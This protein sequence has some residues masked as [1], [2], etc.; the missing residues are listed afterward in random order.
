MEKIT[1]IYGASD[2][3]EFDGAVDGEVGCLRSYRSGE[4]PMSI[5]TDRLRVII[6]DAEAA[7]VEPWYL[8]V[9]RELLALREQRDKV[10]ALAAEYELPDLPAT[11]AELVGSHVASRFARALGVTGEAETNE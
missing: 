11:R 3:I 5:P 10:L 9:C 8:S 1:T 2:L 6:A 7:T 4:G